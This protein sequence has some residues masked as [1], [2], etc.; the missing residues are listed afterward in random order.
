[1]FLY[2]ATYVIDETVN[3]SNNIA[4]RRY[5]HS[6]SEDSNVFYASSDQGS[7]NRTTHTRYGKNEYILVTRIR[8]KVNH[9]YRHSEIENN[10]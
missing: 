5:T 3:P 8:S 4:D 2:C 7:H 9:F 6:V 1:M 10:A